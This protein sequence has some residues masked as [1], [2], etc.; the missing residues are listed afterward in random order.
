[1]SLCSDCTRGRAEQTPQTDQLGPKPTPIVIWAHGLQPPRAPRYTQTGPSGLAYLL[2]ARH[3]SARV[4]RVNAVVP[5]VATAVSHT[6][7]TH[8]RRLPRIDAPTSSA[9]GRARPPCLSTC[10]CWCSSIL[11]AMAGMTIVLVDLLTP[12][13]LHPR[14]WDGCGC[15]AH[16]LPMRPLL[17]RPPPLWLSSCSSYLPMS[18]RLPRSQCW[19]LELHRIFPADHFPLPPPPRQQTSDASLGDVPRRSSVG[20][21]LASVCSVNVRV[22]N[23]YNL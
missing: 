13:L 5:H 14:R 7:A 18:E 21:P 3:R 2:A 4:P 12:V 23:C 20:S 16:R 9:L 17:S 15:W 19:W 1:L 6:T 11:G 22:C 10:S 8:V